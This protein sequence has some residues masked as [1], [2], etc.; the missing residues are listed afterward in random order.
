MSE[1]LKKIET[2]KGMI[3]KTKEKNKIKFTKEKENI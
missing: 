2:K 1:V 3:H